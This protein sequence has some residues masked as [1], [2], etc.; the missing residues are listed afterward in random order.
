MQKNHIAFG[1]NERSTTIVVKPV[2]PQHTGSPFSPEFYLDDLNRRGMDFTCRLL[3]HIA[4]VLLTAHHRN[5]LSKLDIYPPEGSTSL[6]DENSNVAKMPP[7]DYRG[8]MLPRHVAI[9]L[10]D[11]GVSLVIEQHDASGPL[12]TGRYLPF[13]TLEAEGADV[14]CST[15]GDAILSMLTGLH[16]GA[17][18]SFPNLSHHS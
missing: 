15:V 3:G 14:A 6:S 11:G 18:A 10:A 17:F 7:S 1:I 4:L 13:V 2:L 12:C 8:V 5:T 16:P 9:G